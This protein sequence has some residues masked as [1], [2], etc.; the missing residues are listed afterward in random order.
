M[1]ATRG[2]QRLNKTCWADNPENNSEQLIVRRAI[3]AVEYAEEAAM[4]LT[5]VTARRKMFVTQEH[6]ELTAKAAELGTR[7]YR[8]LWELSLSEEDKKNLRKL[9]RRFAV[10]SVWEDLPA[11]MA[12]KSYQKVTNSMDGVIA[13]QHAYGVTFMEYKE[14]KATSGW[15]LLREALEENV[16]LARSSFDTAVDHMSPAT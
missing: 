7:L 15:T 11:T 8:N 2:V 16:I 3:S 10:L 5:E 4:E 1:D 13:Y 14:G 12:G 6:L 9:I